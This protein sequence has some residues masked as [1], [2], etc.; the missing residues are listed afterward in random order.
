METYSWIESKNY[1][2]EFITESFDVY[3]VNFKQKEEHFTDF[4]SDCR[5]IY[6]IEIRREKGNKRIAKDDKIKNTVLKILEEVMSNRC[7]SVVYICDNSDG[8]AECRELLFEKYYEEIEE[9]S[10][11][12]KYVRSLCDENLSECCSLSFIADKN[13]ENYEENMSDFMCEHI[14][15]EE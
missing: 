11:I 2:F 1:C 5:D 13:C 4:C 9:H 6:E 3:W 12:E 15:V 10:K 14:D 8:K 7:H